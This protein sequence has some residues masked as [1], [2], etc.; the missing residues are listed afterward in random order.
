ME[1]LLTQ[2]RRAGVSETVVVVGYGG[3]HIQKLL[4]DQADV[5]LLHNPEFRR[6][7]IRSLWT[8]A[9]WLDRAVLVMDADVWC[10]DAMITRLVGSPHENCFLLDPRSEASGEE[11]MLMVQGQRVV[12]IARIPRGSYDSLGESVG[13]LKLAAPA[14]RLLHGLVGARI[15][16][17]DVDLEHEEVYPQLLEQVKVGFEV[18]D[19]LY[20]TEVDFP[21]DLARARELASGTWRFPVPRGVLN[22]STRPG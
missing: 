12:D 10:P 5:V 18:V 19:D 9:A 1:R 22:P 11:Q 17:G 4:S 2:L 15:D 13:F 8:A 20:W 21:E 3:H 6:G 14:A 7:A 16:A